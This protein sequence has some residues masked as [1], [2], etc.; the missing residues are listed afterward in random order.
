MIFG[1]RVCP[2]GTLH[3]CGCPRGTGTHPTP[4][5]PRGAEVPSPAA[6]P[7]KA[8]GCSVLG[9]SAGGG[10]STTSKQRLPAVPTFADCWTRK[11]MQVVLPLL[12]QQRRGGGWRQAQKGRAAQGRTQEQCHRCCS[13]VVI[14]TPNHFGMIQLSTN[15]L[16]ITCLHFSN[17][18]DKQTLG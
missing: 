5:T 11:S 6:F 15:I 7:P 16:L 18:T 4:T 14:S 17:R 12:C 2:W 8:H 13:T 1:V 9:C 3:H 10:R